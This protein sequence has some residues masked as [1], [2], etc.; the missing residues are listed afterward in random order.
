M[1]SSNKI[2]HKE[3]FGKKL[4]GKYLSFL[5]ADEYYAVEIL[6]VQE[7]IQLQKVTSV[8]G[9]PNFIRGIINLRGKIIP[10]IELKRKFNMKISADTEK[11]AIIVMK[12]NYANEES[13]IMGVIIDEVKEVI[14]VV[15]DSIEETPTLGKIDTN[16]IMGI[17]KHENGVKILLDIAK[18]L[19]TEELNNLS[20]IE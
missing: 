18:I 10:I 13:I 15:A 12:I 11:T 4:A 3:E 19:S 7:I 17:C 9:A 14:D 5:L 1:E 8:P 20:K 2:D 6:K 16:F